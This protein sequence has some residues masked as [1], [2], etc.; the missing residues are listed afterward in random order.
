VKQVLPVLAG[1]VQTGFASMRTRLDA[2][3]SSM[4][5]TDIRAILMGKFTVSFLPHGVGIPPDGQTS[6]LPLTYR[7][8]RNLRS[9]AEIWEEYSTGCPPVKAI[10][11]MQ[12]CKWCQGESERQYYSHRK[13][14]CDAIKFLATQR[15]LPESPVSLLLDNHRIQRRLTLDA[16]MKDIKKR[17]PSAVLDDQVFTL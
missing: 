17:G 6:D 16:F 2:L 14:F 5:A 9:V 1:V 10:D 3:D 8:P 13:V 15:E 11:D 4:A 7:L 12:N